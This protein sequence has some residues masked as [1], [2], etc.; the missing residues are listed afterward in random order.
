MQALHDGSAITYTGEPFFDAAAKHPSEGNETFFVEQYTSK[1]SSGVWSTVNGD[2]LSPEGAPVPVLP[3]SAE[4]APRA[5]VLE[6]TSSGSR[7]FFLDEKHEPGITPDSTAAEGKPDLYEYNVQTGTTID[8]TVDE[9]SGEHAEVRGIIGIGGEGSEEGTY[10]YFVAGGKLAPGAVE[11]GDNLYLRH[12]GATT[13]I[14]TLSPEDETF[15]IHQFLGGLVGV[16]DVVDWTEALN[17]RTAEVSPNGRYVAFPSH[18]ALTSAMNESY[19]IYRYDARAAEDHEQAIVCVSCSTTGAAVPKAILPSSPHTLIN[20]ANRQRSVLSDGRVFFTTAASLVPQDVNHQGDVYEWEDGAPHLISGGTSETSFAVF[21][22]A[23]TNGSD[24][25]FTTGQ[26]LVP[27]DLDEIND[28]YDARED[29]GEA[30]PPQPT[31]PTSTPC[32]AAVATPPTVNAPV[33]TSPAASEGPPQNVTIKKIPTK[34]RLTKQQKLI[35]ALKVCHA[36]HSQK[37]RTRCEKT[38]R[39]RYGH[40]SLRSAARSDR[41]KRQMY[42]TGRSVG[43]G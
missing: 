42:P 43:A 10:V 23:S 41:P 19:E 2:T 31:C 11:G 1:R 34:P 17:E 7:V 20:G 27:Q 8:L 35:K 26:S 21:T 14:A 38:A 28:L 22:D 37:L 30:L 3:P 9:N 40:P 33:S 24:I 18:A 15:S 39:K 13:F 4:E 32:P 29:G 25:F 6:E 12:D 36:K 5:T 16:L